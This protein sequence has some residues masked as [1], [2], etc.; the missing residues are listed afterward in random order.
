MAG[1]AESS[2]TERQQYW[3]KHVRACEA[4]GQTSIDYARSQ[5]I[6]V[7]SLYS[8]R[9]ELARKGLLSR[10]QQHRF[11]QVQIASVDS[12]IEGEWRVQLPN[13]A[14]VSFRGNVEATTLSLVLAA[15]VALP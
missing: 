6:K 8:A 15:V 2:L 13:G 14:A 12:A 5:G 11:Q 3:L 1:T 9:K 7:K 10:P 4:T